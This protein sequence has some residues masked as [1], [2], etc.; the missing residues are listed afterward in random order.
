MVLLGS[1]RAL[2]LVLPLLIYI[3]IFPHSAYSSTLKIEAIGFSESLVTLTRQHG[4]T[5]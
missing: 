1:L 5:S 2:V 3:P 4:V